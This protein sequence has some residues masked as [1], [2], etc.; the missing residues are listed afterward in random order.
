MCSG[1][2]VAEID[3]ITVVLILDINHTPAI[4]TCPD[5]TTINI[6][7]LFRTNNC[8]W[9]QAL[10]EC[11]LPQKSAWNT[12]YLDLGIHRYLVLVIFLVVVWIDADIVE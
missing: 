9:N 12:H 2:K 7:R 4:L 3:E 6:N 8:E 1:Q 10:K 11:Q 5:L